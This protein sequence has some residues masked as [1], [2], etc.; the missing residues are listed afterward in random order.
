MGKYDIFVVFVGVIVF[1]VHLLLFDLFRASL[2][3]IV[4][5]VIY[6]ALSAGSRE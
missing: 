4:F 1:I 3:T 5:F 2:M 6:L